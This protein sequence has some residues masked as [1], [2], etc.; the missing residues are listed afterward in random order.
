MFERYHSENQHECSLFA[1]RINALLTAQSVFVA[2][3][4]FLY[5]KEGAQT[6]LFHWIAYLGIATSSLALIAIVAGC[7]IINKWHIYRHKLID[8]DQ[9]QEL[10]G[11]YLPRKMPDW[12]HRL[13]IDMFGCG[14]AV[15]FIGF[16]VRVLIFR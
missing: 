15:L 2:G 6:S 12:T 7:R 3:A 13:S 1:A 8:E 4:A 14:P 5:N 11:L 16:W 10:K 9:D